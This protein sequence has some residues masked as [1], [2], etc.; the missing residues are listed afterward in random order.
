[1]STITP[2]H[3][4]CKKCV[5][6]EYKGN[7]QTGCATDYLNKYRNIGAEIIEVYDDTCEFY[8]INEK[9]CLCYREDSWFKRYD[10]ENSSIN[11]KI[12]KV[13]EHNRL[14]YLMVINLRN[15]TTDQLQQ[16]M[17]EQ[18][19]QLSVKPQK[20]IFIRYKNFEFNQLNSLLKE[21]NLSC[22]WR[23]QSMIDDSLDYEQILNNIINLNKN[24]RFILSIK[25]PLVSSSINS[26]INYADKTVYEDLSSFHVVCD[27]AKSLTL[28]SAP[29]Y[30][31]VLFNENI[32]ILEDP[33]YITTI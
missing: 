1:M 9:K 22:S 24:Y 20:I 33:K 13:K 8:V 5:F 14:H 16:V 12:A 25:D 31:F 28:F 27:S 26:V 32:N 3:T 4:A 23:I 2:V 11:E 7:S 10:M 21:S 17:K 19:S 15:W 30:R 18:I 6:A 29:S